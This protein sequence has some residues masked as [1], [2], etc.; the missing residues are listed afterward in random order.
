MSRRPA[1]LPSSVTSTGSLKQFRKV[2]KPPEA[3]DA[4]NCLQCPIRDTCNFSAPKVY[5][6]AQLA[7]GNTDWPVN[8]VNPEIEECYARC[9]PE[10][11]KALLFDSLSSN[12]DPWSSA[13]SRPQ[14]GRCVWESDNDVCDDQY[15]TMTWE[16]DPIPSDSH[17]GSP[18]KGRGAKSAVFHMI[19]QTEKQCERRG[20][21]YGTRGEIAYDGRTISVYDFGT[22]QTKLYHPH[23]P[24]G[25]HGGGDDGLAR[26]FVKAIDAVK[27]H[28]ANVEEAQREHVGCTL[29]EIIR[30][31]AIVFAAEEARRERKVVDWPLWWGTE[32]Q[33]KLKTWRADGTPSPVDSG[34]GV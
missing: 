21:I 27:N 12:L 32:V 10:A 4:T 13:P 24:G 29:E 18:L 20:R 17:A 22:Q 2:M 8:I 16:D 25:G 11:A 5:Y 26:Q 30:S 34:R 1:H 14:Y 33:S 9:G 31:H 3:G 15:V 23:Q 28:G 6:D 19:A 7:R